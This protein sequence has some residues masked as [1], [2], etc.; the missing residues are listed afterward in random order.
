MRK[1]IC[2]LR[3]GV[4]PAICGRRDMY[5]HVRRRVSPTAPTAPTARDAA[6]LGNGAMYTT[7]FCTSSSCGSIYSRGRNRGQPG[8]V[9]RGDLAKLVATG[10]IRGR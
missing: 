9:G 5:G 1:T 3:R 8:K 2:P 10:K 6:V 7:Y 4:G